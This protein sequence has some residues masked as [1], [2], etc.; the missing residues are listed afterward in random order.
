VI[1]GPSLKSLGAGA[2]LG[3]ATGTPKQLILVGRSKPKI[4]TVI[5]AIKVSNANVDATFVEI[6]LLDLASVRKGADTIRS[7]TNEIHGMI[8]SAGVMAVPEYQE[9]KDGIESQFAT[10]HVAHFLLTNLLKNELIHGHGVVVNVSS[11]GYELADID[12][13]DVNFDNGK[14]YNSWVAYAQGK[15]ANILFSVSIA[16]RGRKHGVAAFAVN[17]GRKYYHRQNATVLLWSLTRLDSR[18]RDCSSSKPEC[19]TGA[20]H[21][22]F[23]T[24]PRTQRR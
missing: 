19:D 20:L 16:E 7:L 3:L 6:D 12:Y 15:T 10:N 5:D 23:Q 18:G 22:R 4:Q 2:A 21:G 1:T 8:N 17:P 14:K 9:S 13:D 11:S 24:L